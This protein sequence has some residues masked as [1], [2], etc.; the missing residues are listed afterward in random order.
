VQRKKRGPG[1]AKTRGL[2]LVRHRFV[3]LWQSADYR[4]RE[5]FETADVMSEGETRDEPAGR[6][7]YGSTSVLLSFKPPVSKAELRAIERMLAVDPH[8]RLRA[9]RIATLEAQ[10]R[11]GGQLG[12]LRAELFVRRDA[13]GVRLDIEVEA[14]VLDATTTEQLHA[15]R[16][17]R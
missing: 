1:I 17:R 8:A 2:P 14:P 4:W 6:V 10:L 15:P 13:R 9:V 7:Y 11:A 12:R 16:K 5:L 3:E